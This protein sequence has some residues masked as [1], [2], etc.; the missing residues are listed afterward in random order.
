MGSP[1]TCTSR[2]RTNQGMSSSRGRAASPA[3]VTGARAGDERADGGLDGRAA[4]GEARRRGGHRDGAGAARLNDGERQPLVGVAHVSP[5]SFLGYACAVDGDD[6]A[7]AGEGE[8]TGV[9]LLTVAPE[10]LAIAAWKN[11]TSF[12]SVSSVG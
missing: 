11:D 10:A 7:G 2:G 4:A 12:R 1:K 9:V 6:G 8:V 3:S 5:K